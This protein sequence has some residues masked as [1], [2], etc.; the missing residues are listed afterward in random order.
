[1]C[2]ITFLCIYKS[3]EILENVI[4]FGLR[5]A[6][7]KIDSKKSWMNRCYS[8]NFQLL[9]PRICVPAIKKIQNRR[10]RRP[11]LSANFDAA[12]QLRCPEVRIGLI[13]D[14]DADDAD[15]DDQPKQKKRK[16]E[17]LKRFRKVQRGGQVNSKSA[18]L[19]THE[20]DDDEDEF[21]PSARIQHAEDQPGPSSYYPDRETARQQQP[22]S[23]NPANLYRIEQMNRRMNKRWNGTETNYRIRIHQDEYQ[24]ARNGRVEPRSVTN[25][26]E[27]LNNVTESLVDRLSQNTKPNDLVRMVLRSKSLKRPISTSFTRRKD[28]TPELVLAKVESVLQSDETFAGDDEIEVDFINISVP[29]GGRR[30]SL[31]N[32]YT[33]ARRKWRSII[34]VN[35]KENL[36]LPAALYLSIIRHEEGVK[37]MHYKKLSNSNRSTLLTREAATFYEAVMEKA[38][39]PDQPCSLHDLP[40]FQQYLSDYQII[41]FRWTGGKRI[42]WSGEVVRERKILVIHH[43]NH[44]D[45]CTSATGF[46]KKP[47][48]CARCLKGYDSS[49]RHGCVNRCRGCFKPDCP[50]RDGR[51]SIPCF[52]C[53]RTFPGVQCYHRHLKQNG[54]AAKPLCE[55]KKRCGSCG[56]RI[57]VNGHVC[58]GI[59]CKNCKR[60]VE[61]E[62]LCYM[63]PIRNYED[64]DGPNDDDDELANDL[65]ELLI[66]GAERDAGEIPDPT[67]EDRK[68]FDA[69]TY[70]Y[71][72]VEAYEDETGLH[73]ANLVCI[74]TNSKP[75]AELEFFG[76][77]AID[78]FCRWAIN[79]DRKGTTFIA[80]NAKR[81]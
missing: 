38:H 1:M 5:A 20:E 8:S 80:H 72:D 40:R 79:P 19:A 51:L 55:T 16:T 53:N 45:V 66:R 54:K 21:R 59:W 35:V 57:D 61:R 3:T 63:K 50:D 64:E 29:E 78:Q 49:D 6:I 75:S 65:D 10:K 69:A 22:Q 9:T 81:Y 73:H 74:Q 18:E 70:V 44:F 60:Y 52:Q 25:Y 42:I 37:S 33:E 28:F 39:E 48:F 26:L 13:D 43:Q 41:V 32:V 23:K 58:G 15:D 71:Y 2:V 27:M 62:H 56:L 24:T 7:W 76:E 11:Q 30:K 17:K 14:D 12:L 46:L 47:Y 36:C 77:N 34:P 67:P 4:F 31:E 68:R